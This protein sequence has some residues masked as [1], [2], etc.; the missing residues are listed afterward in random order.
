MGSREDNISRQNEASPEVNMDFKVGRLTMFR[1]KAFVLVLQVYNIL[2]GAV[3]VNTQR[4]STVFHRS[5]FSTVCFSRTSMS[6]GFL[7][8]SEVI[9][10]SIYPS[11][12][13]IKT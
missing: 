10:L 6:W 7:A 12:Q 9:V 11:N 1:I 8:G 2:L 5:E 3:C 13:R 4:G